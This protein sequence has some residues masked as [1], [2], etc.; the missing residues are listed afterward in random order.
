MQIRTVEQIYHGE[1]IMGGHW[2]AEGNW[3]TSE[4]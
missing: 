1:V 2:L 3:A 4:S